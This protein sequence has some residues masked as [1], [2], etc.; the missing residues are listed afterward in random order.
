MAGKDGL[1]QNYIVMRKKIVLTLLLAAGAVF[2]QAQEQGKSYL[3]N[4]TEV[5]KELRKNNNSVRNSAIAT[6]SADNK[7]KITLMDEIR[8]AGDEEEKDNVNQIQFL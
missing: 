3:Q 2:S 4:I 6:L 8:W 1:N 7:P 5:V